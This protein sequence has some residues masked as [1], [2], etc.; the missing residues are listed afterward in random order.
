[1]INKCE[2]HIWN[3]KVGY[4]YNIDNKYYFQFDSQNRINISPYIFKE[5][6]DQTYDFNNLF[7][8]QQL[9]GVFADSLPDR[10]G[11]KVMNEY[12]LKKGISPNIIDRLLFAGKSR[13]GAISY[14][15]LEDE[16]E[17]NMIQIN[18]VRDL[19]HKTKNIIDG[20]VD[21]SQ[22]H[23]S[24]FQSSASA[25]GARAKASIV[26]NPGTNKCALYGSN[27][28]LNEKY[29]KN[30]YIHAIIKFD[31]LGMNRDLKN[32]DDVRIEYVYSLLAKKSGINMPNTY[33]T[34]KDIDNK[35]HF[36]IERFDIVGDKKYHMHSLAG[37]YNHNFD[38]LMDYDYLFRIAKYLRTPIEDLTQIYSR[39]VFNYV[40]RNQDD[41]T[42]NFSFLMDE[43]Q[44]WTFS[45]AYDIMYNNGKKFTFENKMSFNGKLGSEVTF[46]DF[47]EIAKKWGIKEYQNIIDT[48]EENSKLLGD[49]LKK[50]EVRDDAVSEIT[51]SIRSVTK[52]DLIKQNIRRF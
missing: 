44:N 24:I 32:V 11:T 18:N 42:K 31:E 47:R 51:S 37:L 19:Y 16:T 22:Y 12:F 21:I 4:I 45:P 13:L 10:F 2:I 17:T 7:Y 26:Y 23:K 33:L 28:K 49:Y 39:M 20:E 48:I 46:E 38:E 14:H 35:Q 34:K 15:P 9:A 27:D 36:V 25:G 29:I 43:N 6:D 41:H 8:N 52:D 50:Y 1:M 5:I 30:G 3:K 40:F